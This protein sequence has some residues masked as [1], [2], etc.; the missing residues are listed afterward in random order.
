MPG[1]PPPPT[2]SDNTPDKEGA[3]AALPNVMKSVVG[4]S[5][6]SEVDRDIL[7]K[8]ITD[9]AKAI[10]ESFTTNI[11]SLQ[12][13]FTDSFSSL[14][15]GITPLAEK[16]E[17]S[18]V[19][20]RETLKRGFTSL[21]NKKKSKEEIN[22]ERSTTASL[23]KS[24]GKSI[25]GAFGKIE[26]GEKKE[27]S[28]G[29]F[30]FL[31]LLLKGAFVLVGAYVWRT[32]KV[33][34]TIVKPLTAFASKLSITG[35][36]VS[37]VQKAFAP[38]VS[39]FRQF[40]GIISKVRNVF[41]FF[42]SAVGKVGGVFGTVKSILGPVFGLLGK[43][44]SFLLPVIRFFSGFKTL[45]KAIPIVGQ[46]ITVIEGI[47]G[48]IRGWFGSAGKG[49]LERIGETIQGIFAQIISGLSFGLFSFEDIMG[50]F[51]SVTDVLGDAFYGIY[52]FFAEI[53][54]NFF[55]EDIPAF[56]GTATEFI[57]DS[58]DT[59]I[60]F[61]MTPINFAKKLFTEIIPE[62]I[63]TITKYLL[64]P[65]E[66]VKSFGSYLANFFTVT[67]P[68]VFMN[69]F[70]SAKW[71]FTER[72]PKF[73]TEDIPELIMGVIKGAS[74]LVRKALSWIP[75]L[76]GSDEPE[77]TEEQKKEIKK[78][79]GT[80]DEI[81][82]LA[83]KAQDEDTAQAI[84]DLA[85]KLATENLTS[86][87][88]D[89]ILLEARKLA[90]ASTPSIEKPPPVGQP[91]IQQEQQLNNEQFLRAQRETE[92]NRDALN[93]QISQQ[94]ITNVTNN[95]MADMPMGDAID[96]HNSIYAMG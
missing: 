89:S 60:S 93:S 5:A 34:S 2:P 47:I 28:G 19:S 6:Q 90:N 77:I 59:V 70:D 18:T 30:S 73:F 94:N 96:R 55:T 14:M 50:F 24:L 42:G 20:I 44:S 38:V 31:G 45:M 35:K 72:I 87:Q 22:E 86:Q 56:F 16:S 11:T 88:R 37:S 43:F 46:I 7:V 9:Q 4:S 10:S 27:E 57:S 75:G 33:I 82:D 58:I 68:S 41:S 40:T 66:L 39:V 92:R 1:L 80:S 48:G 79:R 85:D 8:A 12:K 71:F 76:G 74:W 84:F 36:I 49:I 17:E 69:A 64:G 78:T 62:N 13:T 32:F 91:V 63:D 67:I 3:N 65:V 53:L 51:G 95:S 83:N 25:S 52:R 81:F 15:T 29:F 26:K 23:F 61:L 54:P 21:F